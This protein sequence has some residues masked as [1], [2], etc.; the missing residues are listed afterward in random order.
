MRG[1]HGYCLR[2]SSLSKIM[3]QRGAR[4]ARW[5]GGLISCP[6]CT[7]GI[8]ARTRTTTAGGHAG[9]AAE[10]CRLSGDNSGAL[11]QRTPL[12]A[13]RDVAWPRPG[14]I[15]CTAGT[16]AQIAHAAAWTPCKTGSALKPRGEAHGA[17]IDR[18]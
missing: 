9:G 18:A 11:G 10:G 12:G 16:H 15:D 2:L 6:C 14:G 3:D 8:S 1:D 5:L 13:R 7:A 17:L 4:S